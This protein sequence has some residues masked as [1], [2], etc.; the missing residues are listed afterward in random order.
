[1][2]ESNAAGYQLRKHYM[3]YLLWLECERTGENEASLIDFNE[4]V[5][6]I[7]RRKPV[8][9]ETL[10]ERAPSTPMVADMAAQGEFE[11]LFSCVTGERDALVA[12]YEPR[13]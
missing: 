4:K 11:F 12:R 2:G 3:K 7:K 8:S 1:M 10:L 5:K 13:V 6:K 9:D